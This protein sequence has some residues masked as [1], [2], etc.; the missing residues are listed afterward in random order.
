M[1]SF[2]HAADIH[3]DSPLIGLSRYEGAP[4]EE[5]REATR[6]AL[7][8]LVDY[9]LDESVPLLLIA[10][11]V[12]DGDWKDFQTGLFF[13]NQMTRLHKAGVRVV[14]IRGNHDAASVMTRALPLPDNVHV[15]DSRRPE[16]LVLDDLGVAVHGQSF[17]TPDIT[18]NLVPGYPD[19]VEGMRNIGLLHTAMGGAEGHDR[20]AP[21]RVEELTAKGYDYWALGHVHEH[22]VLH[23]KPPVV[24]SGCIQGRN[25]RE[26]GAKGC[27]RVDVDAGGAVET[28]F[29]PLDVM[30]WERLRIDAD[31]AAD[32]ARVGERFAKALGDALAH[33]GGLPLAVRVAITGRSEAHA[34]L[35][36][37]P[38]ALR[39]DLRARALALSAG[40][41]WVEKVIVHTSLP[42]DEDA[43]RESDT[44]QGDLLRYLDVLAYDADAFDEIRP[45]FATLESRVRDKLAG[46][47]VEL[48]DL[49]D[50]DIRR[51][52]LEDVREL[53]LPMFDSGED[54]P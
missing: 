28:T 4:V 2:V 53:V 13:V 21:C 3:L 27:V 18:D 16:T 25:I 41:A 47:G 20:Y 35:T 48:P 23:P 9:V 11:D 26:T 14:M 8:R 33:A 52:L 49:D 19:A 40:R 32:P 42:V 31:G 15:L 37:D 34:A 36:R 39:A 7:T 29:V 45:D 6:K 46:S 5:V 30:R 1:I 17:E 38:E 43:L 44:P 50:E 24:F 10:G 12:Y 51:E 22:A 54:A